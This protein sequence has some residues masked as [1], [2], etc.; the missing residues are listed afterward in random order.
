MNFSYIDNETFEENYFILNG[1]I[2]NGFNETKF[3]RW[4]RVVKNLTENAA[5][6]FMLMQITVLVMALLPTM[7]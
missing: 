1:R 2:V 7:W 4:M 3:F 6:R 5:M